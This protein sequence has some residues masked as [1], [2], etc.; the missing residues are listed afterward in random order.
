[1]RGYSDRLLCL[2]LSFR[3]LIARCS[4]AFLLL[5]PSHQFLA[6]HAMTSVAHLIC[7]SDCLFP[8]LPGSCARPLFHLP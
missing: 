4:V 7:F 5:E 1:M 3:A 8:T 6:F 2:T